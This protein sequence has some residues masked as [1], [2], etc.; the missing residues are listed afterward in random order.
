MQ[1]FVVRIKVDAIL[2]Q[3]IML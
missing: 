3:R 1:V 2:L